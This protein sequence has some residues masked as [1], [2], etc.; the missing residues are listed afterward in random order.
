MLLPCLR[1]VA[2]A[3]KFNERARQQRHCLN[4]AAALSSQASAAGQW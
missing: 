4:P 1:R 3:Q 2:G